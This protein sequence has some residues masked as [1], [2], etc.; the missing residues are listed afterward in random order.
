MKDVLNGESHKTEGVLN[1]LVCMMRWKE[2]DAEIDASDLMGA[3]YSAQN[4]YLE[5]SYG[6]MG[7]EFSFAGGRDVFDGTMPDTYSG[8]ANAIIN[9]CGKKEG[10]DMTE[11][12]RVVVFPSH[13]R[14]VGGVA[15]TAANPPPCLIW[16]TR[17][18]IKYSLMGVE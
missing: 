16:R 6:R 5:N 18:P 3:F 9:Y 7:M 4:F 13:T 1:V 11:Y 2:E 8:E 14:D 15:L 10:V 12:D 17:S